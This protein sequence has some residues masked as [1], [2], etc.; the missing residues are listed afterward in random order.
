MKLLLTSGGIVA[1]S[2]RDALVGM[3]GKPLAEATA[4]FVPT[5]EQP[6]GPFSVGSSAQNLRQTEWKAFGVLELTALPSI[7]KEAW[8]PKLKAADALL[9]G[10]GDPMY[11][12]YWMRQSGLADLLPELGE[13]VYVGMSAGS[14]VLTPNIGQAFVNW[15]PPG[16]DDSDKTLGL[17][18][19]SMFPH[20]AHPDLPWNTMAN[21]EKWAARLSGPRYVIDDDT[22]IK[23]IDGAVEVVSEGHWKLLTP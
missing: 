5:A 22:A 11:L 18:N 3:M 7:P 23:V 10:G 12:H 21:A 2:I 1:N 15:T 4:L 9:V 6:L 16:G 20:L 8:L 13:T 14:M 19:F 17:V